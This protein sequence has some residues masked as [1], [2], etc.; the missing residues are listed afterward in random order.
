MLDEGEKGLKGWEI[1][2]TG[3]GPE[4]AGIHEETATDDQ[5]FYSFENLPPGRYIVVEKVMGGF[6]PTVSPVIIV[7]VENGM[8]SMNNNF[9]NRRPVSSPT[10]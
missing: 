1:K 4:T 3:I 6:V 10:T 9:M 7:T 2:L 5:G 8:N